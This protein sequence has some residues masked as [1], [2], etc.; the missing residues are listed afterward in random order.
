MPSR[1]ADPPPLR[2][3]AVLA[4]VVVLAAAALIL[5]PALADRWSSAPVRAAGD[6]TMIHLVRPPR[7]MIV[8][9]RGLG[10]TS[11]WTDL[12]SVP[13]SADPTQV[14]SVTLHLPGSFQPGPATPSRQT[15]SFRG[16]RAFFELGTAD[17]P[18]SFSWEYAPGAWG[19]ASCILP[20]ELDR[21]LLISLA[22][23]VRFQRSPVALPFALS[24]LPAGYRID[25]VVEGVSTTS[26]EVILARPDPRPGDGNLSLNF[27][28]LGGPQDSGMSVITVRGRAA[29]VDNAPEHTRLCLQDDPYF[30][31]MSA[32]PPTGDWPGGLPDP[33]NFR[34]VLVSL[35]ENVRL[36]PEL[37]DRRTWFPTATALPAW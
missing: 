37:T 30:V 34:A 10:P 7:G 11:E 17:L 32:I 22:N 12:H 1:P 26:A 3:A 23:G 25:S 29:F 8:T 33:I 31:C 20:V 13:E 6:W 16:E 9:D 14:C 36:A 19:V 21:A 2:R 15:A 28:P 27:T 35:A 18:P 24:S 5:A 4:A